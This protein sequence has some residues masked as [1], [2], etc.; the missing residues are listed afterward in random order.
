LEGL[1]LARLIVA[2]LLRCEILL[3]LTKCTLILRAREVCIS[4]CRVVDL[5]GTRMHT[6]MTQIIWH[7]RVNPGQ[8]MLVTWSSLACT[9]LHHSL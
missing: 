9:A 2:P 3:V 7:T 8:A 4:K 6:Y 1:T 5:T